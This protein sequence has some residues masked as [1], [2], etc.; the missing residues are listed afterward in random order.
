VIYISP[1]PSVFFF[2]LSPQCS[3]VKGKEVIVIK[4]PSPLERGSPPTAGRGEAKKVSLHDTVL[5]PAAV[6]FVT[7]KLNN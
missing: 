6:I 4:S 3:S 1:F 7:V 5:P 2:I